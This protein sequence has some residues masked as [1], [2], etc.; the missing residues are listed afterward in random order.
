ML[1][2]IKSGL[3]SGRGE[4]LAWVMAALLLIAAGLTV[5]ARTWFSSGTIAE[6]LPTPASRQNSLPVQE[7]E[8][9]LIKLLTGG[10]SQTEVSGSSGHY[11]LV[12][13]RPS[14]DEAVVLQLK[15]E[16]GGLVQEI[17]MPQEKVNWTTLIEL[18]AG[19]YSLTVVNHP[20]WICHI[21]VE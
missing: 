14:R 8:R 9:G 20:G 5:S 15:T 17:E 18:E 4:K 13:T 6:S 1:K 3:R 21:S 7:Q 11:R 12:M 2:Q 16:T 19:S 10:F